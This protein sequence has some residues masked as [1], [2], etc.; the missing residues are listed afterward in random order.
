M[1]CVSEEGEHISIG[2]CVSQ[3]EEKISQGKCVSN[4]SQ[5]GEHIGFCPY[6]RRIEGLKVQS[7]SALQKAT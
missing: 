4:V 2:I 5:V 6:Q 1:I 3:V 7:D